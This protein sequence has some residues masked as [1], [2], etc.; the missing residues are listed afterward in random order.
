MN[1]APG[2]SWPDL[3]YMDTE[4][5]ELD[6]CAIIARGTRLRRRR[7]TAKVAAAAVVVAIAPVAVV[8]DVAGS[9]PV[10]HAPMAGQHRPV[11]G[12]PDAPGTATYGGYENGPEA[13]PKEAGIAQHAVAGASTYLM[14]SLARA[15]VRS[16]TTLPRGYGRLLAVAGAR[17]GSGLWFTAVAGQLK[18]FRLS[19]AGA[20]QSW[21]L[22]TPARSVR[23]SSGVGLAV[24]A[25]GVAWVGVGSTLVS[26]DTKTSH[27]STWRLP[28]MTQSL[29][30]DRPQADRPQADAVAVSPDGHV[31]V[32]T[33]HSSA[34]SVLDPRDGTFRQIT[35]PGAADQPLALGYARNGTLGIG[36][37]HQ[38]K[39]NSGAV[40]L[41]NRTGAVW[42]VPVPQ[43]A[44]VAAY[45][46]SGLLVGVTSLVVVE[47]RGH[48]RP[49][50]M[51]ED[52]LDLA[53][54]A[55]PPAPLPGDRLAIA[56]GTSILTFPA[57][58]TSKAIATGQSTLWVI[59]QPRCRPRQ[60]CPAGYQLLASDSDGDLWLVPKADPRTI[61]L[62]SLR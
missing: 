14:F 6:V 9:G 59:P 35:L 54:L 25:A 1:P 47:A 34:V 55:I 52:S 58:T 15:V 42:S 4:Q 36:Y 56:T 19:T 7:L 44:A 20:L 57:R 38:G 51:P 8:V 30:A 61:E 43:P 12:Q 37:Q 32:A 13:S 11:M 31:A 27:V 40:L 45:G 24:S 2:T 48:P 50:V 26:F 62:V 46:A 41:V 39:P 49:L 17:A 18:L 60:R 5:V 53:G 3:H 22:P 28:A 29:S 23:A 33:S 10:T 21:P 16:T